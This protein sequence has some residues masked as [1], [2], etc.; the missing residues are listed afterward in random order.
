MHFTRFFSIVEADRDEVLCVVD[1][2]RAEYLCFG[3]R[4]VGWGIFVAWRA[5]SCVAGQLPPWVAGFAARF[6]T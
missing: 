1:E 5:L 3:R 4:H 6:P 2:S